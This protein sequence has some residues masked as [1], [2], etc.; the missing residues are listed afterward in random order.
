M[1]TARYRSALNYGSDTD[2]Q[3]ESPYL[4]KLDSVQSIL[5]FTEQDAR[6]LLS[7]LPSKQL[8]PDQDFI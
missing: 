4:N 3:S 5:S 2:Q 1:F 8:E 7:G 6:E